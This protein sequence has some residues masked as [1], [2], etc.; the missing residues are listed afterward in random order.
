MELVN[1]CKILRKKGQCKNYIFQVL[2]L[3]VN[4]QTQVEKLRRDLLKLIGVGNFS[5]EATFQDPCLSFVVPEVK[6]F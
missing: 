5:D 4:T 1:T 3:D 6:R 2:Q